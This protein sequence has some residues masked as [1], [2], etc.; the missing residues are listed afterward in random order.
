MKG[1]NQRKPLPPPPPP[2]IPRP[3]PVS[4]EKGVDLN[5]DE[6]PMT[7][8][9]LLS[10]IP[11]ISNSN[12]NPEF[13]SRA[14]SRAP[15]MSNSMSNS[16]AQQ[17]PFFISAKNYVIKKLEL[18]VLKEE[19]ESAKYEETLKTPEYSKIYPKLENIYKKHKGLTLDDFLTVSVEEISTNIQQKEAELVELEKEYKRK[20]SAPDKLQSDIISFNDTLDSYIENKKKIMAIIP[21]IETEIN[22]GI[23]IR[24]KLVSKI[25]EYE[26]RTK[27][28]TNE[29]QKNDIETNWVPHYKEYVEL[30]EK[31]SNLLNIKVFLDRNKELYEKLNQLPKYI[32][33]G[34]FH[35]VIY[36]NLD[37]LKLFK[38]LETNV[39]EILK[40]Y[41]SDNDFFMQKID[42]AAPTSSKIPIS[43]YSTNLSIPLHVRDKRI[44][45]KRNKELQAMIDDLTTKFDS[46]V[47]LRVK[48]ISEELETTQGKLSE[49]IKLQESSEEEKQK[50]V[51]EMNKKL[52]ESEQKYQDEMAKLKEKNEEENGELIEKM[53]EDQVKMRKEIERLTGLLNAKPEEL[54]QQIETKQEELKVQQETNEFLLLVI[55]AADLYEKEGF[56]ESFDDLL[57]YQPDDKFMFD[58]AFSQI[59]Q[60]KGKY[61]YLDEFLRI[62]VKMPY[63]I[64]NDQLIP[65]IK[66]T[67]AF[68]PILQTR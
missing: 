26:D 38:R 42:K 28:K 55:N 16:N 19:L 22:K 48:Q 60:E 36:N 9:A 44:L 20:P 63:Q 12:S 45:E 43:K 59:E 62:P 30:H 53:T 37:L 17:D 5:V 47:E 34:L 65:Q 31:I 8:E 66:G 11:S 29:T 14:P 32:D 7:S 52:S 21:V 6:K 35:K 3:P 15:S 57:N 4:K 56:K 51:E 64:Y 46:S 24:N 49:L 67:L 1:K 50:M 13:I 33:Q 58:Y 40:D 2:I 18:E 39:S 68:R 61:E 41:S 10:R 23:P 54:K 27:H 25:E